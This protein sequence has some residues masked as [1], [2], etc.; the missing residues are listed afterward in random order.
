[1]CMSNH[2]ILH[3]IGIVGGSANSARDLTRNERPP[4]PNSTGAATALST[5]D[6]PLAEHPPMAAASAR[7][8][9]DVVDETAKKRDTDGWSSTIES[10][11]FTS[12]YRCR[13]PR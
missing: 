9:R 10:D 5:G 11:E 8:S 7:S 13:R 1:M 4:V 12:R 6:E 3:I 2:H